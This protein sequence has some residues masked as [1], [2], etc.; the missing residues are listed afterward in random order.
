MVVDISEQNSNCWCTVRFCGTVKWDII[1]IL[2]VE[3]LIVICKEKYPVWLARGGVKKP[4]FSWL[5][6]SK[7]ASPANLFAEIVYNSS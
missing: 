2:T 3:E 4:F 5:Q 1:T 7:Y 6:V